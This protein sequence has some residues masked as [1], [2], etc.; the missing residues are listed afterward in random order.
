MF[1]MRNCEVSVYK[2]IALTVFGIAMGFLEAAV[3]VYLRDLYYPEGFSFPLKP[4]DHANLSMEYLR[5]ISTIAMLCSVGFIA[6]K[7]FSTRL[8]FFLFSFGI[9]DIFYYIWL[10][11]FL[12]WPS[13][14]LTWDI[15][16][17]I[18]VIWVGPVLAPIICSLTMIVIAGTILYLEQKGYAVK[19]QLLEAALS[20]LG[21]VIIFVTFIWD[22]SK[23]IIEAYGITGIKISHRDPFLQNMISSYIP[24]SYNWY[25]FACGEI[26]I[27]FALF[28]LIKRTRN[29]NSKIFPV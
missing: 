29:K 11:V 27:F 17:L 26:L 6:G 5:E 10:K 20:I 16:F 12:N 25:L 7:K 8:S 13:S 1:I 19:I 22:Y 21:A 18:P 9:W 24:T 14:L 2:T 4:M 15:L 23:I 28:S 3:V